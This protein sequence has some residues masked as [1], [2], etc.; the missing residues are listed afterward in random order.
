VALHVY[1]V[2]L[3]ASPILDLSPAR[4][5]IKNIRSEGS[6]SLILATIELINGETFSGYIIWADGEK[7]SGF[8]EYWNKR[9]GRDCKELYKKSGVTFVDNIY[10]VKYKNSLKI[11]KK[12]HDEFI[13]G[14][15]KRQI[16]YDTI[17]QISI[18]KHEG[19]PRY[20]FDGIPEIT[21]SDY[22]M[23]S[24]RMALN[25]YCDYTS[26]DKHGSC[27][28]SYSE[29]FDDNVL[30]NKFIELTSKSRAEL[31]KLNILRLDYK[32]RRI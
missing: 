3:F 6:A 13:I 24:N 16:D 7:E 12:T 28:I 2:N 25:K 4:V 27:L 32:P 15:N 8:Y 26:D 22:N 30:K 1:S 19:Y 10:I 29:A 14:D 9:G 17:K 21:D 31:R 23:I 18:P 20:F 5:W 11:P